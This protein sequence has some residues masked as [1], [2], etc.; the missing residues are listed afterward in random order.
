MSQR[1]CF[2]PG[3]SSSR[4]NDA[5]SKV[6]FEIPAVDPEDLAAYLKA[7]GVVK[8]PRPGTLQ[9]RAFRANPM[10]G[11]PSRSCPNVNN[12]FHPI[13]DDLKN[14][15][16]FFLG[17]RRFWAMFTPKRVR[18]A[19]FL[20]R[21]LFEP[22]FLVDEESGSSMDGFVPCKDRKEKAESGK[23]KDKG[24][25]ADNVSV[26][27]Q[28]F[29]GDII[30]DYLNGSETVDLDEFFDFDLPANDKS[31]E[32]PEFAEASRTITGAL[33]TVSRALSASRQEARMAQFKAEMADKEVACLKDEL[34]RE[35]RPS[36]AEIRRAYR[37]EK[38]EVAEMVRIRR[39]RFSRDFKELQKSQK[40]LGE[41]R[42]C[43]GTTGGLYLTTAHNYSYDVEY[44][45]QS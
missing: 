21:S 31:N 26:E 7:S 27:G 45:R 1:G 29:A 25:A 24:I 9:P 28:D 43:R 39:E 33:L 5:V 44:V 13:P 30:K 11:C 36:E 3:G 32:T 42:E 2:T 20:H 16:D 38:N 40:A 10:A 6:E 37:R 8:T 18:H 4:F 17:E 14:I 41:Y 19:V 23:R 12:P 34:E 15:R 22:V 35:R